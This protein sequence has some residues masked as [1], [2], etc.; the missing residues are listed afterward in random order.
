MRLNTLILISL[1]LWN[2]WL[3]AAQEPHPAKRWIQ[4]ILEQPEFQ[5]TKEV[6]YW[7]YRKEQPVEEKVTHAIS[8]NLS[9]SSQIAQNLEWFLWIIVGGTSIIAILLV[10]KNFGLFPLTHPFHFSSRDTVTIQIT[11]KTSL[12]PHVA[13][14][15]WEL[16][17]NGE[18]RTAI[19]LLY[20]GSLIVLSTQ[21][22]VEIRESA[23][24]RECL[25]WVKQY[26]PM[27]HDYFSK[28]TKVWQS[29]AYAQHFPNQ[30]EFQQLCEEWKH[31]FGE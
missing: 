28:L 13:H 2:P 9:I 24:E 27:F 21:K 6:R 7:R 31:H 12:P 30:Q 4:D 18:A 14:R 23:T 3:W 15:A 19:S 10:K 25:N 16:W 29:I 26:E 17:Q 20:R 22:G 1:W 11:P 8:G 5:T